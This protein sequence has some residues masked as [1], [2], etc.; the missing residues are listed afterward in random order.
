[1]AEGSKKFSFL[2]KE[3]EYKDE[4]IE[5]S[6]CTTPNESTDTAEEALIEIANL[7]SPVAGKHEFN[8]VST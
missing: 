4:S 7:S 8:I 1:M 3:V 6:E 2:M 5:I